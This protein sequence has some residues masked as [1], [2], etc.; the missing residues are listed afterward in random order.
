[1]RILLAASLLPTV[2]LPAGAQ[3]TAGRFAPFAMADDNGK[4]VAGAHA[5]SAIHGF[6][7]LS[8][9]QGSGFVMLLDLESANS[10]RAR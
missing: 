10:D 7:S 9:P 1:M 6:V 5:L 3:I 4:Q 8:T 2:R